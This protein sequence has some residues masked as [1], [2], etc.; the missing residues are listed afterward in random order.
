MINMSEDHIYCGSAKIIE[1]NG[2][3]PYLKVEID[4]TKIK[5]EAMQHIR[6]VKFQDGGH[7]L[8]RLIVA[9]MKPENQTPY[10]THSVKVDTFDIEAWKAKKATE[11]T[12]KGHPEQDDGVIL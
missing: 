3:E 4:L 1:R 9:P 7:G 10:K 2:Q 5:Q 11:D 8:I 6:K 12:G